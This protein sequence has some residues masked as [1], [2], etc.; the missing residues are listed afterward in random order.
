MN[1]ASIISRQF[2][3]QHEL[4]PPTGSG[5][6]GGEKHP[7]PQ[8]MAKENSPGYLTR[9]ATHSSAL[10]HTANLLTSLRGDEVKSVHGCAG[11]QVPVCLRFVR[12]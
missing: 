10:L 6:S 2:M 9:A 3:L 4:G 5:G 12:L 11:V 7:L 1:S 8:S